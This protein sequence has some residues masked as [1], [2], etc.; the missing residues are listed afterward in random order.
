MNKLLDFK[1]KVSNEE[2]RNYIRKET[3][4]NNIEFS[5]I[6]NLEQELQKLLSDITISLDCTFYEDN[7]VS[8]VPVLLDNKSIIKN[9]NILIN[10]GSVVLTNEQEN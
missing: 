5:S 8:V 7:S 2:I 4:L 3:Q 6:V 10:D 1:I 9:T